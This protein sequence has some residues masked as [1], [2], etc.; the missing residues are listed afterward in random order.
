[1]LDSVLLPLGISLILYGIYK[2][3][4]INNDYFEKRGIQ[5]IKPTIALGNFNENVGD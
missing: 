1:M 4:T 5:H 3:M 2:W